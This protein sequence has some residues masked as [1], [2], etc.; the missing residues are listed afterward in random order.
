MHLT[1][2]RATRVRLRI[3]SGS[4]AITWRPLR[5]KRVNELLPRASPP[6]CKRPVTARHQ[7]VST[8]DAKR[9]AER[10]SGTGGAGQGAPCIPTIK[11]NAGGTENR[12]DGAVSAKSNLRDVPSQLREELWTGGDKWPCTGR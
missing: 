5:N 1:D 4:L 8:R 10:G 2:R 12:F 7:K 6:Q 9:S 11:E 3:V